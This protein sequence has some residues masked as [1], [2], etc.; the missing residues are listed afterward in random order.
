ML[1]ALD[2]S[3]TIHVTPTTWN[4]CAF[5][6]KEK[7]V[8]YTCFNPKA[9]KKFSD[10]TLERLVGCVGYGDK[11]AG[12][13]RFALS[14][15]DENAI[16]SPGDY[17]LLEN[18]SDDEICDFYRATILLQTNIVLYR[19]CKAD[20]FVTFGN[21]ETEEQHIY[22]KLCSKQVRSR[23]VNQYIPIYKL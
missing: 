17:T 19:S 3:V 7:V 20:D 6:C 12:N 15:D 9:A 16:K 5:L 1:S 2:P 4:D 18:L 8:N 10:S 13:A 11:K 14:L 21:F 22:L 23:R